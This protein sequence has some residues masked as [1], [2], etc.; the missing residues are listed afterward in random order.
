M[1]RQE[2]MCHRKYHA[3]N[4]TSEGAMERGADRDRKGGMEEERSAGEL[5]QVA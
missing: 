4:A 1:R 3:L 5:H 2:T